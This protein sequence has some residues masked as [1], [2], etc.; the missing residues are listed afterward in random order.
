MGKEPL[1]PDDPAQAPQILLWQAD[2]DA[3][4][5][6]TGFDGYFLL[7]VGAPL[8]LQHW[9][10][11]TDINLDPQ[12][13]KNMS[14]RANF[15][16]EPL[17][18][19]SIRASNMFTRRDILFVPQGNNA[20][21]LLLNVM[22]GPRDYTPNDVGD[23][24]VLDMDLRQQ[25]DHFITGLNITWTPTANLSQRLNVGMDYSTSEY[26]EERPWGFYSKNEGDSFVM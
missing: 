25:I 20:E 5:T 4:L 1:S 13:A 23:A 9:A 18:N 16:F 10:D 17:D 11:M 6:A 8:N 3:T 12:N 26:T 21:G 7:N 19:L 22:R 14:L 24:A 2:G 15:R